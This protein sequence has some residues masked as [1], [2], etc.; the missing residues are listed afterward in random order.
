MLKNS[1]C[2]I[3]GI[4]ACRESAL[5]DAGILGW[6]DFLRH[7]PTGLSPERYESCRAQITR[8]KREL[9]RR[10]ARFFHDRLPGCEHW[11]L[12]TEFRSE[13]AFLDIETT[14]LNPGWDEITTIALYDGKTV[15][16]YVNG[17]NLADFRTEIRRFKQIVT[18]N[19]KC[20][21]VP[22]LRAELKFPM[23]HAHLDLRYILHSLGYKG[24]LKG[25]ERALGV[26]RKGLEEVNGYMA[27]LLWREYQR[28]NGKAL[29]TLLAYNIADAMNLEILMV[30][31]YNEKVARTPFGE[32]LRLEL[33]KT[34]KIPYRPNIEVIRKLSAWMPAS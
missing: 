23:D 30:K 4:R 13:T 28:G 5:W 7:K 24:G 15:K 27:V 31:A 21:D 12:F 3:P 10:N 18:Y 26:S 11:R 1:F 16:T 6:S 25:C 17:E 8:S 2:F 9:Q 32:K 19:G 14:G 20:F 22:F 33:P 29:E 34:P